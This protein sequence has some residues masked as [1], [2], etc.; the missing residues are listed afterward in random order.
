MGFDCS[1]HVVDEASLLRF[2]NRFLG[3][4]KDTAF[5]RAYD[6]ADELVAKTKQLIGDD[7]AGGGRALGELALMFT[8]AETP[9]AYC[10]GF[11]L[12]LWD[13]EAM[14]AAI[15]HV[16][17]GSVEELLGDVIARYP[18][19]ARRVPRFFDQNYC[20][21]PFVRAHNVPALLAFVERTLEAMVPG[22]RKPYLALR[23]VLRV[24]AERK[25]AYWE[26]TDLGVVNAN[27]DWLEPPP[28]RGV[29]V[30]ASP[31]ARHVKPLARSGTRMLVHNH[32]VLHDVDVATFPPRVVT[33]EGVQVTSAAFLHDGRIV[34]RAATDPNQR[35]YKFE[36]YELVGSELRELDLGLSHAIGQ[37]RAASD[38]ALLFPEAFAKNLAE[39]VP[40]L[41]RPGAGIERIAAPAPENRGYDFE[42][43]AVPFDTRSQ[44][45]IWDGKPYRWDGGPLAPF[46]EPLG[47]LEDA[48]TLGDGSIV[49]T[50]ER[51]VLRIDR[52]G[53]RTKLVPF[54][55]VMN[56]AVG[57]DEALVLHE[58]D[59]PEA[60]MFKLLWPGTREIAH[61][62]PEQFG[63]DDLDL[64]YYD[65]PRAQLVIARDHAWRAVPWATLAALP[66]TRL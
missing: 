14:G 30:E 1:L 42:V 16:L 34:V 52:D 64:F 11:A 58:G 39:L 35:P 38:G 47:T 2:A 6:D 50:F 29:R 65:A 7:P 28:A 19:V 21:G 3:G 27:A 54:E 20:V 10:R 63:V 37:V 31:L 12:S 15:P 44:L 49:G 13:D 45:V 26:G 56:L 55:N 22:D 43:D 57:P 25:M 66:R 5:D 51:Q 32:F 61:V 9:H 36:L 59:N 24:A 46:G 33:H 17:L 8:S 60:D 23:T 48:C 41:W 18:A 53:K 4:G 40:V 62:Q